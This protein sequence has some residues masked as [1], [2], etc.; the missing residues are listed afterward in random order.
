MA[1]GNQ[2]APR[3]RF[4]SAPF[5]RTHGG[6]HHIAQ[7]NRAVSEF[8]L[9]DVELKLV[10]EGGEW[11]LRDLDLGAS[12]KSDEPF[13]MGALGALEITR[14]KL[15]IEDVGNNFVAVVDFVGTVAIRDL[16]TG[17]LVLALSGSSPRAWPNCPVLVAAG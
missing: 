6:E 13:S 1:C 16:A 14:L 15:G 12:G 7:R 5:A 17:G 2:A 10:H 4:R 3:R 8:R 11:K 9:A